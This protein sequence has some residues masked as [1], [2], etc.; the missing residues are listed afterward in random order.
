MAD[1]DSDTEPV[2]AYREP[3]PEAPQHRARMIVA[4]LASALILIASLLL[5]A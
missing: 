3:P 4:A 2:P 5:A 1:T